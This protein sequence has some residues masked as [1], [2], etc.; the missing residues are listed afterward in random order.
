[1]IRTR[2]GDTMESFSGRVT[3]HL[4]L[5]PNSANVTYKLGVTV[6]K[7]LNFSYSIITSPIFTDKETEAQEFK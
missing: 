5:E 2:Y 7:S 6:A 1:M 4:S 3:C